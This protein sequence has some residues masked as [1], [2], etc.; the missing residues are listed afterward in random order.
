MS[1]ASRSYHSLVATFALAL[2]SSFSAGCSDNSTEDDSSAMEQEVIDNYAEMVEANYADALDT[3]TELHTAA[4]ELTEAPSKKLLT[5]ARNAWL[6]S[7]DPYGES[8]A[9]RFYEG[10]IDNAET[11]P[12]GLMN[13]WPID[14][15]YIDYVTDV[16]AAGDEVVMNTGIINTPDDY[17]EIDEEV[18]IMANETSETS[19]STGYHAIEFLLWG[20]DKSATGP[21]DRQYTDYLTDGDG[22]HENQDRR[23]Q[24]LLT[25]ADLLVSNLVSVHDQWKDS[26][27]N[28]RADFVT[29]PHKES[30]LD[31]LTGMGALAGGEL[32]QERMNVAYEDRDQENEHSCFSDNTVADLH[33]NAKSV[34]NVLLGRYGEIDGRGIDELIAAKDSKLAG[35]MREQIQTA[36]DEIDGIEGPFDQA[37]LDLNDDGEDGP[38]RQHIA[39]AIAAL[40]AFQENC[41][42]AATK[43]GLEL[44]FEE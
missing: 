9:F 41:S 40:K 19:I 35:K 5:D 10:P 17:P 1:P 29:K 38:N 15:S 44:S 31:I 13:A 42:L 26:D 22:T 4:H 39:A 20:Q 25:A 11:G 16:D 32:A 18:L 34:Q 27:D 21:G 8:E 3:A 33:N 37:I 23:A 30:L 7:R 24:Y 2:A 12:E 43:L 6:A 28:Y 36:L 14:E